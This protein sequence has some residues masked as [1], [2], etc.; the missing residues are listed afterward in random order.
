MLT[1]VYISMLLCAPWQTVA[2]WISSFSSAKQTDLPLWQIAVW[3][4]KTRPWCV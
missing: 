3:M 1:E 4:M 2:T